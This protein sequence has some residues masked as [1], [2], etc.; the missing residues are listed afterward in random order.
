MSPLFRRPPGHL[1]GTNKP[2]REMIES[3]DDLF[4]AL[5]RGQGVYF[6]TARRPKSSSPATRS[7]EP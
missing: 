1:F 7:I 6:A 2:T 3:N 5:D 4:D